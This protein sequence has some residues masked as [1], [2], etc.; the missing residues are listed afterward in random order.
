LDQRLAPLASS[1]SDLH[2]GAGKTL[3][4]AGNTAAKIA[5]IPGHL[6]R[7]TT[8]H[9]EAITS[10]TTEAASMSETVR[11]L[12]SDAGGVF[13][14]AGNNLARLSSQLDTLI[15][16]GRQSGYNLDAPK[17]KKFTAWAKRI[18]SRK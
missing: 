6:D 4:E 3:A 18:F 12:S 9:A 17:G 8:S 11:T 2:A 15:E 14:K 16:I 7:I 5:E 1:I 10:L 13:D